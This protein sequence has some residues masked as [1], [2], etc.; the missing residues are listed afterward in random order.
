VE[1]DEQLLSGFA[2]V[3]FSGPKMSL[4][5]LLGLTVAAFNFFFVWTGK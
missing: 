2:S 1:N 3:P 5:P 4:H